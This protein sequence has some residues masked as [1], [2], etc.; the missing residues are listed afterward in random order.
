MKK[1]GAGAGRVGHTACTLSQNAHGMISCQ[2]G[3]QVGV[4][5]REAVTASAMSARSQSASGWP[6]TGLGRLPVEETPRWDAQARN[7]PGFMPSE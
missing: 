2:L 1:P 5:V 4:V 6:R 7:W 3:V